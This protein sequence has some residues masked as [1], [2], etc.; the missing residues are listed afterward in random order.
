V[1][2]GMVDIDDFKRVNDAYGHIAGDEVIRTILGRIGGNLRDADLM[3]RWGG[4]EF[5]VLLD[6]G[7]HH[8]AAIAAERARSA[9][10]AEPI[11]PTD[12][13]LPI[14]VTVSIGVAV[15]RS[16]PAKVDRLVH[17]A[18]QALFVAK[19]EGRNRYRLRRAGDAS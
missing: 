6:Q 19:Q 4:E 3:G 18:D 1:A 15:T 13:A 8:G 14:P 5:V 16:P 12:P 10:A 2:L 11:R 17:E 7:D 9:V